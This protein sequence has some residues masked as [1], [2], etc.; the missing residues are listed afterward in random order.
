MLT[1]LASSPIPSPRAAPPGAASI[2]ASLARGIRRTYFRELEGQWKR[3]KK[4]RTQA[5]GRN[6]SIARRINS[7]K[8]LRERLHQLEKMV[9][10]LIPCASA[11][12]D[13]NSRGAAFILGLRPNVIP[14]LPIAECQ[15]NLVALT[16]LRPG[17]FLEVGVRVK[18]SGHA[19]DRVVQRAKLVELPLR[20]PDIE[21]INAEF[22]DALPLAC[23]ATE[24]LLEVERTQGEDCA[25]DTQV[26]LP[27]PHGVFLASWSCE[28]QALIIRTFIDGAKLTDPQREAVREIAQ[29]ADGQLST[30]VL[31]ILT[32]GWMNVGVT[33]LKERLLQTWRDYG[34][35]F[36]EQ[37]LHPGLSDRAW[38]A[39]H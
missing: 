14:T 8:Q 15:A 34:W 30:Q 4:A 18:V 11:Y 25:R 31:N 36:D 38:A 28:E 3:L 2:D 19:V 16:L 23:I 12:V 7:D 5:M 27:A 9:G 13:A 39:P 32:A 20:K 22:A 33:G 17:H 37:R 24:I 29:W 1:S 6:A 35:R 21:A 10:S 26:L